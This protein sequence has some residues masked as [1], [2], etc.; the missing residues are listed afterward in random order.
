MHAAQPGPQRDPH[1][2]KRD[3]PVQKDEIQR[4]PGVALQ[5]HQKKGQTL[6]R[7]RAQRKHNK[8]QDG[9]S[10]FFLLHVLLHGGSLPL[11]FSRFLRD[12]SISARA[13]TRKKM[14]GGRER[15][16][17][18]ISFPGR[19]LTLPFGRAYNRGVFFRKG[20]IGM[21]RFLKS[22][23]VRLALALALL[24][25]LCA[26]AGAEENTHAYGYTKNKATVYSSVSPAKKTKKTIPAYT[27]VHILERGPRFFKLEDGNYVL[28][29]DVGLFTAFDAGEKTVYWETSQ[30]MYA[31]GNLNHPL[32]T[33]FPAHTAVEP[34]KVMV[35]F[36]VVQWEGVYGFIPKKTAKEPPRAVEADPVYTVLAADTPLY[37]LPLQGRQAVFS[38]PGE[39]GLILSKKAGDFYAVEWDGR[40]YYLPQR[41]VTEFRQA[42]RSREAEG[43]ADRE[44]ALLDIP[45]AARGRQI[46]VIHRDSVCALSYSMN[47]FAQ[48]SVGKVTGFADEN[49]FTYPGGGPEK[50]YLFLN[51]STRVLTVYRADEEGRSTGEEV[52]RVTVAIGRLTTPTPSGRFTLNGRERWHAF[53]LS[54]A[55]YAVTYTKDRFIHGP[56]YYR[57]SEKTLVTE[58]LSDFGKMA[59]GGCVRTPYD[60]VRWIYFHCADGTTLEIV[61]GTDEP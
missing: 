18:Y 14:A 7:Q 51:K 13:D 29:S 5:P 44:I 8:A 26:A 16:R 33:K 61:N 53:A 27:V 3:H 52:F 43:Y 48:V 60:Q 6:K 10:G 21:A 15:R 17:I 59:T 55:P 35:D 41:S 1:S 2:A 38:L 28:G 42:V 36:Y 25:A 54:Y 47:G 11:L 32:K 39:T 34:L 50:Y 31:T 24:C 19:W 20:R 9:R 40:L 46:G 37:D 4:R 30:T 49:A 23:C 56:L 12:Y 58:R 57:S 22:S 45:D